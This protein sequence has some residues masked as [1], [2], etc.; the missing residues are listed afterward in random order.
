MP[1]AHDQPE[2]P[3]GKIIDF[4]DGKPRPDNELEQVRQNFERTLIE[5][6]RFD[7]SDVA[8]DFRVKLPDGSRT[9]TR[10]LPLAVFRAGAKA[11]PVTHSS[12]RAGPLLDSRT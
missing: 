4:I 6:Y 12:S 10:K 5:E 1:D 9:V 8:V 11:H 7:K 2:A 3:E